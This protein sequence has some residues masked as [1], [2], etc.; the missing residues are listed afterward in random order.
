M[1]KPLFIAA[2]GTLLVAQASAL[3]FNLIYDANINAQA[4]QGFKDASAMWSKKFSDKVTVNLNI[5]FAS[6]GSGILGQTSST[7]NTYSYSSYRNGLLADKK[8][9]VDTIATTN[10]PGGSSYGFTINSTA[11]SGGANHAAS[12]STI[13][14]TSANAKAAGIFA[15]NLGASD[16]SI[17][18]SSNFSFD[19]DRS[20]GITA[21][22]FDFVGIAAHEIGHALGF[23]SGLDVLDYYGNGT[24]SDAAF[25]P[26]H[27]GLDLFRFRNYGGTYSRSFST[28]NVSTYFSLDG[29]TTLGPRF[30]TGTYRG[31]G[32]QASHWK[33]NLG[34]GIMDPTAD[35]GELLNITQNDLD[36]FDAIGWDTV[37]EP[38]TMVALGLGIAGIAARRR[39]K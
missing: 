31:D 1:R 18:F 9:A 4:L 6:L 11:N 24:Y 23:V 10:L 29:G 36:A 15:G 39:R 20:N 25:D 12:S 34:I 38:T 2:L 26:W 21:G 17:T 22:Q 30:S 16:G 19:F 3:D 5:G 13:R 33:D 28:G 14:L 32:W 37:P 27:Y 7:E 35:Y 8:S